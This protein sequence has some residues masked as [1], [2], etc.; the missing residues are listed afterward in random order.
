MGLGL[1]SLLSGVGAS[2]VGG[3]SRGDAFAIGINGAGLG[4]PLSFNCSSE[5]VLLCFVENDGLTYSPS[6]FLI[7]FSWLQVLLRQL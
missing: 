2:T 6:Y 5:E 1:G 3:I 4:E 7:M